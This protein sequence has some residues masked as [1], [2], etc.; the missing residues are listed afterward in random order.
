MYI[1]KSP[2][3][4]EIDNVTG[5]RDAEIT[6]VTEFVVSGNWPRLQHFVDNDVFDNADTKARVAKVWQC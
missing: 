6:M 3:V 2:M 4:V 1:V 5:G